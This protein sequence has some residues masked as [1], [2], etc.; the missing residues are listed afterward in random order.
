MHVA[1]VCP[2]SMQR[3]GGVQE[4]AR[5]LGRALARLGHEVSLFAPELRGRHADL[6]GVTTVS[7]G[8]AVDVPANRS[9]ASLGV[10]PLMLVRFELGLDPVDVV[11]LH[12]AFLPACL[13]ALFR[14][15]ASTPVV[16]TFHA[17]A[18]R[19]L[20]YAATA[21]ALRRVTRRLAA[22]TAVSPAARELARRYVPVDPRI[23]PNGV[24]ADGFARAE[25]DEWARGLDGRVV[26]FVGRPDRRKGFDV[27]LRAFVG[28]TAGRGDAHLI[29]VPARPEDARI[30][31]EGPAHR[32]HCLGPVS[33]ERLLAL[34]RAAD[35]VCAPSLGG[36]SFGLVVVEGLA[37]GSAV[38]AS[39]IPGYRFAGGD[40]AEY[41]PPGDVAAWRRALA[42]VLD[43]PGYRSEL[44]ERG[45]ARAVGFDWARIAELSLGVYEEATGD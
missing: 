21:P 36:E 13:L 34:H 45:P 40:A 11:H 25:P 39:D 20:P 42:R 22:T 43:D 35:V 28:A 4:H 27:L 9:V 5:G 37:G 32:I 6:E 1:L 23:V 31:A 17:S 14:A 44:A 8:A 7:L 2:Y 24:D 41:V 30:L 19:F 3:P 16:G 33:R 12:E 18:E 29:C 10:H 26:L 15:P 38:L